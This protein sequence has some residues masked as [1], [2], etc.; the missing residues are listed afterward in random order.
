MAYTDFDLHLTMPNIE[1]VRALYYNAFKF[2]VPK[3]ITFELSCK[4]TDTH[5]A[6]RQ[7]LAS[8][9]KFCLAK[10]KL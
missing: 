2:P 8:T 1:V 10:T 3:F 9:L 5:N 4:H 6:H 7:T